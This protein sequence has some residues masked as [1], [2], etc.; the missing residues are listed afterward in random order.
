MATIGFAVAGRAAGAALGPV[1]AI[2]GGIAF[3]FIGSFLDKAFLEPYLFPQPKARAD[4]LDEIQFSHQDEGAASPFVVVGQSRIEGEVIWQG[5]AVAEKIEQDTGGKGGGG[6][7]TVGYR[8]SYDV[9]VAAQIATSAQIDKIIIEGQTI[10]NRSPDISISDSIMAVEVV[11]TGNSTKMKITSPAGG[12]DLSQFMSG[13]SIVVAGWSHAANNGTFKCKGSAKDRATGASYV[14]LRNTSAVAETLGSSV[15]LFQDLDTFDTAK[16]R[17]ITIYTGGG[18]QT[19]DPTIE[20]AMGT[21][22]VSG[23]RGTTYVVFQGLSL[24]DY[25]NRAP[26]AF[27]FITSASGASTVQAAISTLCVRGGLDSGE[28]DV[29]GI[30][31]SIDGQSLTG[32]TPM[33]AAIQPLLIAFDILTQESASGLRFFYRRDAHVIDVDPRDLGATEGAIEPFPMEIIDSTDSKLPSSVIIDHI[34]SEREFQPGSQ[35]ETQGRFSAEDAT[36]VNLPIAMTGAKARGIARRLRWLAWNNRRVR[37]RLPPKYREVQESD[38]LRFYALGEPWLLLVQRVDRGANFVINIEAIVELRD[39][40]VQTEEADDP[41]DGGVERSVPGD[42]EGDVVELP[43]LGEGGTTASHNV[44]LVTL[45]MRKTDPAELYL[46]GAV[47][48]SQDDTTFVPLHTCDRES[49]GGSASSV[50]GGTGIDPYVWDYASTVDVIL[51][52]GT[53]ESKTELEVENGANRA[54]VGDEII[55]FAN[56]TLIGENTYRLSTL[57]RG[58]ADTM[59]EMTGHITGERFLL[60]D[61]TGVYQVPFNLSWIGSDRYFRLVAGGAAVDDA[62]SE[63]LSITGAS[64][65][66]FSPAPG[67]IIRD[68]SSNITLTWHRRTRVVTRLFAPATV[69]L[70]EESEAYEIDVYDPDDPGTVLRTITATS[71]TASYSATEQGDDGFSAWD[72]VGFRIYQMSEIY[73]RG[74]PLEVEG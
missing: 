63:T 24:A 60:L 47:Y 7:Q 62:D 10:Y 39:V 22:N 61:G 66:P 14:L 49:T 6:K 28:V 41:V 54:L 4:R 70:A 20:A 13:K 32:P 34:D 46:Q 68:G 55:G 37:L 65:R 26:Q 64:L 58:L 16:V 35:Q 45:D 9:A 30:S 23:Y 11:A 56:A 15:T 57:L 50:L 12:P 27:T 33:S 1:G 52:R 71:E 36:T 74:K 25:G 42:V 5:E 48:Q 3:G 17:A 73:G 67:D 69:P 21:G 2:A 40:L 51:T 8:Y 72:T 31:S 29:T 18:G 43:P 44:P 53:L 38:C 59:D 19:A